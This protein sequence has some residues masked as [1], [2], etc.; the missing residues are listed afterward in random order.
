MITIQCCAGCKYYRYHKGCYGEGECKNVDSDYYT[1]WVSADHYC[2]DF[3]D[4]EESRA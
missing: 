3:E 1:D 4:A 2:E